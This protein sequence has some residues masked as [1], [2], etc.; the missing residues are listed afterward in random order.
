MKKINIDI[1]AREGWNKLSKFYKEF[2][3]Y[4]GIYNKSDYAR[5]SE[6][7]IMGK[8]INKKI[9]AGSQVLDI[10]CGFGFY[11][12][13]AAKKG[14]E[15]IG[16]DFAD[17]MLDKAYLYAYENKVNI[18]FVQAHASNLPFATGNKFDAVMSGMDLDVIRLTKPFKEIA[19]IIKTN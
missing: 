15:V 12:V 3:T 19:R 13:L 8:L 16:I 1:S 9:L 14:A 17:R 10:G 7:R 2:R 6:A 5:L 18:N 4:G 11:S